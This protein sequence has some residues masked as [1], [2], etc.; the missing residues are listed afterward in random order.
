LHAAKETLPIEDEVLPH[1]HQEHDDE[2]AAQL[3]PLVPGYSRVIPDNPAYGDILF[4]SEIL[5]HRPSPRLRPGK[6]IARITKKR[7]DVFGEA[8]FPRGQRHDPTVI[9]NRTFLPNEAILEIA[10]APAARSD[11]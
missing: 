8:A 9:C 1:G 11:R 3:F 7:R 10:Q 2:D 4:M 5:P 6:E